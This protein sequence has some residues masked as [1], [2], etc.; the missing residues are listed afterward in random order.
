VILLMA[1]WRESVRTALRCLDVSHQMPD[2]MMAPEHKLLAT[3]IA[4]C[5][6]FELL[7][8]VH[9]FANG[10]GHAARLF[11]WSLLGRY[12]YWPVRWSVEPKPG[13]PYT[14]V[15]RRYRDGDRRPLEEY[16][17]SMIAKSE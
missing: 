10:N 6:L 8:R 15:I 7:L 3:V 9:P 14:E 11:L 2:W 17:M 5:R 4:G 1:D 12:G 16:V 13:P